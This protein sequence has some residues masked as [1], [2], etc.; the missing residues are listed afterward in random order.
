MIDAGMFAKPHIREVDKTGFKFGLDVSKE[1]A[2]DAIRKF[3]DAVERGDV[4]LQKV[5][6]GV[7]ADVSDFTMKAIMFTYAEQEK[8]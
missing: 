3:A 4:L 6:S 8:A 2:A 7:V 1:E 5:Q